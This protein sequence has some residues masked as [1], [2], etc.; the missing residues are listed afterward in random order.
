M[1]LFLMLKLFQKFVCIGHGK[2]GVN[3]LPHSVVVRM[4]RKEREGSF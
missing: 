1:G 3:N 4:K 2:M